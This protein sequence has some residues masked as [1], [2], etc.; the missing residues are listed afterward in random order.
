MGKQWNKGEL[1]FLKENYSHMTAEQMVKHL[2][3]RTANAIQ[4]KAHELK[5]SKRD[6][7]EWSIKDVNWLISNYSKYNT[8]YIADYL[9]RSKAAVLRQAWRYKLLNSNKQWT[10]SD[11]KFMKEQYKYYTCKE[12]AKFLERTPSSVKAKLHELGI[13]KRV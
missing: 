1:K 2:P 13:K 7:Q 5:L 11:I 12:V 10:M 4:M 8:A 9:G 3:L 6:W